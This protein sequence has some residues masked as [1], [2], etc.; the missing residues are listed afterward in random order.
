MNKLVTYLQSKEAVFHGAL[1]LMIMYVPH[2]ASLFKQLEHLDMT[3]QGFTVLNWAYGLVLAGVIEFLILIFIVN[4]YRNTGKFYAVV[5]FFFNAFYY[6]YWFISLRDPTPANIK[7]TVI[8]LFICLAHSLA[9]WQLSELF[10]RRLTDEKVELWCTECES[11]P[12]HNK[13]SLEGHI[14]KS[15]KTKRK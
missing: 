6:D 5:G 13:R 3:L 8:S 1:A 14:S 15:H 11:G 4:G 7:Y 9:V 10:F 2:A 12:F